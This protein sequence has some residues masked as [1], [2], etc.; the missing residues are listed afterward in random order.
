MVI[1]FLTI[2]AVENGHEIWDLECEETPQIRVTE[3]VTE[4]GLGRVHAFKWE[5]GDTE[6]TGDYTFF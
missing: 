6:P 4:L 1:D 5:K 2:K 3:V